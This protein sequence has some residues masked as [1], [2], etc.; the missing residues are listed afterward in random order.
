MLDFSSGVAGC[1]VFNKIDLRKGYHQ[2]PMHPADVPKTAVTTPFGLYE[3]L[4]LP[5]GLKNAG[6]TFQC[7]MDRVLRGL[8]WCFW[9]L[10][11]IITAS[12]SWS[13]HFSH[14]QQ[15]FDRLR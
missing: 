4:R 7:L 10:D 14:L 15:L 2:I 6:S 13:D 11:D 9:Y 3:F 8:P 5:F 1:S 12:G